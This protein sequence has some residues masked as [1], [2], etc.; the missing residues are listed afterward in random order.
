M[1]RPVMAENCASTIFGT[2]DTRMEPPPLPAATLLFVAAPDEEGI[3]EGLIGEI[4]EQAKA[5]DMNVMAVERR[6]PGEL[7]GDVRNM[8][9]RVGV[10]G[11]EQG[12]AGRRKVKDRRSGICGPRPRRR[13]IAGDAGAPAGKQLFT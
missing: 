2:T 6:I 5:F 3:I 11:V 9:E 1:P 12:T 4:P 10:G 8:I 13:Q 7:A